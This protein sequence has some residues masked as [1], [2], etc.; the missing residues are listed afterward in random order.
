MR[1]VV[2]TGVLVSALIHRQGTTGVV[3]RLLRDGR[4]TIIYTI[5]RPADFLT[6]M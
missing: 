6:R 2:D 5:L 4:F 1:A 3:L